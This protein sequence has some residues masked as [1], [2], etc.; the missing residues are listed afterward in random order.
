M[1][2]S[3]SHALYMPCKTNST[4]VCRVII[5]LVSINCKGHHDAKFSSLLLFPLPSHGSEKWTVEAKE[6]VRIKDTDVKFSK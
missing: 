6:N 2:F 4:S 5:D 3:I 1:N